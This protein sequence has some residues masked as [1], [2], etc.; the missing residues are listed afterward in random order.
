MNGLLGMG[1]MSGGMQAPAGVSP[2]LYQ[3]LLMGAGMF[4]G[5]QAGV[6][7]GMGYQGFGGRKQD[8]GNAEYNAMAAPYAQWAAQQLQNAQK[9]QP[10]Y[11]EQPQQQ[12]APMFTPEQIRAMQQQFAMQQQNFSGGSFNN[13]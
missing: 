9:A 5:G 10:G 11:Q 8:Q 7:P 4:G 1:P 13:N 6:M 12:Q 2:E 3:G